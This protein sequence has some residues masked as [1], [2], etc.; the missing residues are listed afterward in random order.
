MV[1][2][3]DNAQEAFNEYKKRQTKDSGY[4]AFAEVRSMVHPPKTS[5]KY[6]VLKLER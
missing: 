4:Y 6:V 3:S 1:F 2:S 5:H